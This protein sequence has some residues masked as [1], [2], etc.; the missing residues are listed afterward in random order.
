MAKTYTSAVQLRCV[1]EHTCASCGNVYQYPMARKVVATSGRSADDATQKCRA[2]VAK[3]AREDVDPQPC[4]ACGLLQPDMVGRQR[5]RGHRWPLWVAILGGVTVLILRASNGLNAGSA[6]WALTGVAA[7][8]ALAFAAVEALDPNRDLDA[9]RQRASE[10]VA[11]GTVKTDP[12]KRPVRPMLMLAEVPGRAKP[13]WL[14]VGLA[15]LA[16]LAAA[17]PEAVRTARRWPA[18]DECYPPVVGPGDTTRVYM[19]QRINSVKGFYRGSV[20]ATLATPTSAPVHL[21]ADTNQND[22]GSTIY[23]KDDEK[24]N[25]HRPWV[26]LQMP[27]DASLAG[28]TANA[29]VHLSLDYPSISPG[30]TGFR[31]VHQTMDENFSIRMA[32]AGAG[33]QFNTLWWAA[34]GAAVVLMVGAGAMLLRAAAQL[35][36]RVTTTNVTPA[37]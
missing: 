13:R 20:E 10:R 21:T 24:Q 23:V 4:P 31:T 29:A 34:S 36:K 37:A 16:P 32:P 11:E 6:T 28:Q 15:L 17:A 25:V 1:K 3:T 5:R 9:N 12:Q 19:A 22:W 18:N 8:V 35:R 26:E 2:K 27:S 30:D 33:H 7:V 14:L